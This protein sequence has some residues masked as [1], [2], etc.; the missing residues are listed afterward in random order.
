[1]IAFV[2]IKSF[3]TTNADNNHFISNLKV[4]GNIYIY[5]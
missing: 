4:A 2:Y 5:A 3:T 1:M